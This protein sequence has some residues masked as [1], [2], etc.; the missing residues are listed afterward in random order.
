MGKRVYKNSEMSELF[1][2]FGKKNTWESSTVAAVA[3]ASAVAVSALSATPAAASGAAPAVQQAGASVACDLPTRNWDATLA[4]LATPYTAGWVASDGFLPVRLDEHRVMLMNGDTFWGTST[5]NQM[6]WGNM[7]R[8]S[9]LIYDDRNPN[10]FT[11]SAGNS[12][13]GEF[14]AGGD[15]ATSWYWPGQAQKMGNVISLQ[16][17]HMG[18]AGNPDAGMWN[19]ALINN[20][21][22]TYRLDGNTLTPLTARS[23]STKT[24]QGRLLGWGPTKM[25]GDWVYATLSDLRPGQWG[26][27]IYLARV[28]VSDWFTQTGANLWNIQYLTN[29]GTWQ[30]DAPENQLRRV[31]EGEGEAGGSI[32]YTGNEYH[33][34]FKQYSII[35]SKLYDYHSPTLEGSY[36][37]TFLADVPARAA[38]MSYGAN[39]QPW[40]ARGLTRT[41]TIN[42]N[43]ENLPW[44]QFLRV[45]DRARPQTFT[46]TLPETIRVRTNMPGGTRVVGNVTTVGARY[47]GH[48]QMFTCGTEPTNTSVNNYDNGNAVPGIGIATTDSNGDVCIKA[49][50]PANFIFDLIGTMNGP[51]EQNQRLL[52]TR[53][54]GRP[55]AAG[56]ITRVRTPTP[57]GGT[58]LGNVTVVTPTAGGHTRVFT[59]DTP[60][61]TVSTNN[62]SAGRTT[63]NFAAVQASATQDICIYSSQQTHLLFDYAGTINTSGENTRLLDTRNT[64]VPA[65]A[66]STTRIHVPTTPNS[67]ILGNVTAVNPAGTG[68]TR[69]F[70]CDEAMPNTS[71]SNYTPGRG[72][73]NFTTV[74]TSHTS[75]VCVYTAVDTH[76]V[77]DY[78]GT[79]N[80]VTAAAPVRKIDTR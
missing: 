79:T 36:T 45:M 39:I 74:R 55:V 41:V 34:V 56:S 80:S 32:E 3:A 46:V 51:A 17:A 7:P 78:S 47:E 12:G 35:G 54:S 30:V 70:P 28:P 49:S 2:F 59:C 42:S 37:R 1:K 29:S 75:D 27:D 38:S 73:A 68:Y 48:T 6:L 13:G 31:V 19:F 50:A 9:I 60:L 52:D 67:T 22:R 53:Q 40:G 61:P 77:F 21:L 10:C 76:L 33:I 58:V 64:G 69:V 16:M 23:M 5:G 63:A 44:D 8:N 20:V 43:T 72:S 62:Y 24:V 11:A 15:P 25:V 66:G 14:P 65:K 71:T 4:S 57:P 18:T 26:H